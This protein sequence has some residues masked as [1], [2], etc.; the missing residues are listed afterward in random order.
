MLIERIKEAYI[1]RHQSAAECEIEPADLVRL[2]AM[3][4]AMQAGDAQAGPSR[5]WIELCR[6]NLAQLRRYGY[7]QF[8]RTIALNYFTWV[9]ILPWDAQIRY[10][11][12]R[13]PAAVTWRC[14]RQAAA[15]RRHEYFSPFNAVQSLLHNFLTYAC[16]AYVRR[17]V[18]DPALLALREPAEGRPAVIHDDDGS[19]LSQ[20]LANSILEMTALRGAWQGSLAE[21]ATFLELGAGYG[22]DAYVVLATQPQVR[23]VIVDIPPALWVAEKYLATE[24]PRKR[25]FRY[26]PFERFEDVRQEFLDSDV[27]FFLSTQIAKLPASL[28]DVVLNISSLHEMRRDQVAFYFGQFDRLLKPGGVFYSKQWK[29]GAVLF[30]GSRI[31]REDYPVPAAWTELFSRDAP[32]QAR[33]FEAA[34]RK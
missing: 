19:L 22:R 26:R 27:A 1:R 23:Y 18:E 34:Y 28:A 16:W 29:N 17:A 14:L 3:F 32:I 21:P 24:F 9:R 11:V 31:R 10:L 5:Y 15:A 6:M 33:F 2:D 13:L 20:D 25:V 4:A 12:R 7:D 8:K 30:E